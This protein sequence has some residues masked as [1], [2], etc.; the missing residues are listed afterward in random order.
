MKK[1]KQAFFILI[2][3][4][5]II[6]CSVSG[7]KKSTS[8]EYLCVIT[9]NIHHGVGID[10][11]FDLKRIADLIRENDADLVALQEVDV[12]TERTGGLNTMEYLARELS[13]Y[14][15]FG[16]NLE[17]QG[18][19]YGNGILSKYPLVSIENLHIPPYQSGEQRGILKILVDYNGRELAFWN[20]HLDHR[21][22]DTE[23][24]ESVR[25]IKKK[26]EDLN[27]P[28]ILAGDFNDTPE[29]KALS[30]LNTVFEDVW[31][32][33]ENDK[34]FTFPSDKPERRID[35]VFFRSPNVSSFMLQPVN[36]RVLTSPA[37]DHLPL[38]VHFRILNVR[39]E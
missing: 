21:K 27:I 13:M 4:T 31:A 29:S 34:G 8:P 12:E 17:F 15:A 28:I 22:D 38:I 30:E 25:I 32:I 3:L 6:S 14:F 20:I 10:G 33:K 16:K 37:S 35:Y 24:R 1:I 5:I 23:R 26:T 36:A 2:I 9:Y 39:N 11:T 19:G 18:G 7:R